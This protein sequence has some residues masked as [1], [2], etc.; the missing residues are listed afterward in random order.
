VAIDLGG[1]HGDQ[2][3]VDH[4]RLRTKAIKQRLWPRERIPSDVAD[5]FSHER[6]KFGLDTLLKEDQKPSWF[7]YWNREGKGRYG[8]VTIAE[9]KRQS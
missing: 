1:G 6:V 7:P 4:A 2:F 8:S 5:L 3:E 9:Q